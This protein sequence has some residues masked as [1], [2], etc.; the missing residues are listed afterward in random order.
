LGCGTLPVGVTCGR[1]V[2]PPLKDHKQNY[3]NIEKF[4]LA[5]G[6]IYLPLHCDDKVVAGAHHNIL[7]I[8]VTQIEDIHV[9]DL[10]HRIAGLEASLLG[11]AAGVHLEKIRENTRPV[12]NH[13]STQHRFAMAITHYPENA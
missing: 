13:Y 2:E 12:S 7:G 4:V 1:Q 8:L 9:I 10:D 6:S 3:D 5:S 11:Q